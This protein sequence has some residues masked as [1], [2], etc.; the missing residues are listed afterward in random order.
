MAIKIKKKQ[1]IIIAGIL[2]AAVGSYF[3]FRKRKI[4]Y[5][6]NVWCDDNKCTEFDT[7][8]KIN[9]YINNTNFTGDTRDGSG[10]GTGYYQVLFPKPHGLKQGDK[11]FIEQDAGATYPYY[12]GWTSVKEVLNPFVVRTSK[13]R[14]GTSPAEGGFV[15]VESWYSQMT[16]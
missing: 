13:A 7:Q 8:A 15:Y 10:D 3:A 11:I 4:A 14:Q 9:S 16:T 6:D 5:Y 1:I 2:S 12:D